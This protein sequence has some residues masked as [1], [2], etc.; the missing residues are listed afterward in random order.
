MSEP[1]VQQSIVHVSRERRRSGSVESAK[2]E[3]TVLAVHKFVTEPARV[4]VDL[5][6]TINMG[7][8]ESVR[9]GVAVTLP[10]YVEE[11][12]QGLDDAQAYAEAHLE[13]EVAQLVQ[14]LHGQGKSAKAT[15]R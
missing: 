7:N 4:R 10:V 11:V 12:E 8:Y 3:S 6:S 1:N 5:S 9:V 15:R 14:R 13:R 2:D